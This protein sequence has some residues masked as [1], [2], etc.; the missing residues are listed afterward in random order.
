MRRYLIDGVAVVSALLFVAVMVAWLWGC[1][2]PLHVGRFGPGAVTAV[3]TAGGDL[4]FFHVRW[5]PGSPPKRVD[6]MP[7]Q[8]SA[9]WSLTD[10]ESRVVDAGLRRT[11][12]FAG[13]VR[14]A[15]GS[16]RIA[17]VV[18]TVPM[19]APAAVLFV[20]PALR[21]RSVMRRRRGAA[22]PGE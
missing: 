12:G 4:A 16:P 13:F 18:Y 22:G 1:R 14:Y 6:W 20:L 3:E 5:P 17:A 8:G 21:V 19:W 15:V 7:M 2:R 10:V 9:P 11:H